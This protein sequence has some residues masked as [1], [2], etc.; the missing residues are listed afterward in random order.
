MDISQKPTNALAQN[1]MNLEPLEGFGPK[2]SIAMETEEIAEFDKF[3]RQN[4]H[5]PQMVSVFAK[6]IFDYLREKEVGPN[7]LRTTIFQRKAIWYS[8]PT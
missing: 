5:N 4:K 8:R 2:F 1:M 7:S 3:D 6:T